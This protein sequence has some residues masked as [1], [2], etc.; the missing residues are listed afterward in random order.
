MKYALI[1]AGG[2][3]QRAGV[4]LPKQFYELSGRPLLWY[5]LKAFYDYKPE[6][7]LVVVM[8][9]DYVG[10]WSELVRALPEPERFGHHIVEGGAT[11]FQSVFN[12]LR[13]ISRLGAAPDDTVFIHDG[14]RPFADVAMFAEGE[15]CVE[16]GI[17]AIPVI[18][19]T[20]SLR[21]KEE[22]LTHRVPRELFMAVQTPQIFLFDDIFRAYS[23]TNDGRGFTDD[24]SVAE[25]AGIEIRTF[26]GK[27]EN[28]KITNPI[29][30]KIAEIINGD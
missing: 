17:G 14:A 27:P 10:H 28:I 2:V 24:A 22:G 3:G 12:G 29:D 13:Y 5:S 26:P 19:I 8:H 21:V 4:S 1:L 6:I 11:R 16:T 18:P 7:K 23:Q 30:F 25:S 15:D 20:D 9:P